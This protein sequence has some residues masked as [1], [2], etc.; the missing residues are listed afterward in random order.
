MSFPYQC[1]AAFFW[2]GESDDCGLG[3][4]AYVIDAK[5]QGICPP[6]WHLPNNEELDDLSLNY[7]NHFLADFPGMFIYFWS[8]VPTQGYGPILAKYFSLDS[9]DN[10]YVNISETNKSLAANVR[11]VKD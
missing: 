3:G 9:G 5:H 6:G 7:N 8:A 11:C 4:S 2:D 1:N 10:S